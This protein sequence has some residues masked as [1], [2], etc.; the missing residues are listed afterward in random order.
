[1]DA[2]DPAARLVAAHRCVETRVG[3]LAAALDAI[4]EAS[5]SANLDD[6]HDPEGSTVGFERAQLSALLEQQKV[7][8]AEL[9]A[10]RERVRRGEYGIC[11]GCGDPIGRDRLDAQPAT[12]MCVVCARS[13]SGRSAR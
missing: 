9:E 11:A 13:A 4:I 1:M 8:L 5:A 12:R 10:A 6:E 2:T 7:Q 3:E